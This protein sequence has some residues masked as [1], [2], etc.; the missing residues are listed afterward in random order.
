MTSFGL[1]ALVFK[2]DLSLRRHTYGP[3]TNPYGKQKY[4]KS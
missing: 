3:L 1:G 4:G 2:R